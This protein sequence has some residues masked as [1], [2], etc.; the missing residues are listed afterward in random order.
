MPDE[1]V[2]DPDDDECDDE[3]SLSRRENGLRAFIE[4]ETK[5]VEV[6]RIREEN[7][8]KELEYSAESAK[9]AKEAALKDLDIRKDLQ[10]RIFNFRGKAITYLFITAILVI[11]IV[12]TLTIILSKDRA[13]VLDKVFSFLKDILKVGGGFLV[14]FLVKFSRKNK[15]PNNKE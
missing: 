14:G 2:I 3:N 4:L 15:P 8:S 12:T 7:V 13:D 9:D 6:E 5:R 10:E 11:V 1:E